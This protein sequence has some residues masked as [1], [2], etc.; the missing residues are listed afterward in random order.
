L[1]VKN[2]ELDL[3]R[4]ELKTKDRKEACHCLWLTNLQEKMLDGKTRRAM[5][6][7]I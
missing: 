1:I 7:E 5:A 6:F 2:I 3:I 4:I